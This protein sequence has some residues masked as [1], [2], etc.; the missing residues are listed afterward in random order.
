MAVSAGPR[1]VRAPRGSTSPAAA[2][3]QEAALRM[4]MNNLDPEVAE[5]PDDLVVYGGTGK[6]AR[7]WEAF[8]A[9]VAELRDLGRR[10][11]AARQSGKPVGVFR[12]HAWAPRVLIANSNL[13]GRW[14]TWEDFR[15]L[16]RTG[17]TMYGQMTAGLLDLHRHPGHPAGHLRDLR[18]AGAAALRRLAATAGVVAH[19]R[20]RRHGRRAAAGRDHERG[21]RAR[22]SRSIRAAHRA[23]PRDALPRPHDGRPRRGARLGARGRRRRARRSRSAWSATPPRSSPSWSRRGERLDV[24]TDQTSRP[25]RA[26]RLRPGRAHAGRALPSCARA[27]PTTTSSGLDGLDGRARPGHARRSSERGAIT[28][29]YGNNIRAAGPDRPASRTPSTSRA[30]CPRTSARCSARARARSAGWRSRAIRRTSAAPTEA[31][32]ELSRTTRASHAGS[33]WPASGSPSRACPRASAGWATASGRKAGLALQRAGAHAASCGA[34]RHR[35]RPPRRGLG[36]LA[37]PRDRGHE[38]RLRRHRRLAD[39]QRPGQHRRRRDLGER[40][41]RRRRRHRLQPCTPAWSSSPTAR[42]QAAQKLERVL[43]TDPGMGVD[44][45]RRRRLRAG[46][47]GRARARRA[48]SRCSNG[49]PTTE[50]RGG[51]RSFRSSRPDGRRSDRRGRRSRGRRPA[52]GRAGPRGSIPGRRGSGRHRATRW[53]RRGRLWRDHRIRRPGHDVRAASRRT[54]AAGTAAAQPCR[55]RRRAAADARR[56]G[57]AAASRQHAGA[58]PLGCRPELIER[59][60]TMLQLGLHPVVPSQGSVGASGDLAPLA[61]RPAAHRPRRGREWDRGSADARCRGLERARPGA[62]RPRA[63]GGPGAPQRHSAHDVDR[64]ARACGRRPVGTDRQRVGGDLDRSLAR[65]RRRLQRR[66]PVDPSAS[67]AGAHRGGAALAAARQ[68]AAALPPRR[69]PPRPGPLLH[70]LRAAGPRRRT[71]CARAPPGRARH[72]DELC[73]GQSAR[74]PRGWRSPRGCPGHRS[75]PGH[76]RWQL[77]WRA[78]RSRA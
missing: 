45:P 56:A 47:R 68:R 30:S 61:H 16:E 63:R 7:S 34:H 66:L 52:H 62:A 77:P 14:A 35:P 24:V 20:P 31:V 2:G 48:S 27:T 3:P 18:G 69:R 4:L 58:G 70:P 41:P 72:R 26:E 22:A 8:D 25:R 10:R 46:H 43:T 15:E 13:V 23:P 65:H 40:P 38:R 71:R 44:P 33:A 51:Q 37:Q 67:R 1:V 57:H 42:E 64:R 55:R 75:R 21:R 36:R 32:L 19:R 60:C 50:R 74:L 17:L 5:R 73:D 6:A 11:D 9:I 76:Q 53:R 28:F 39:P 54:R 49:R 12:T 29:D 78:R 59:L